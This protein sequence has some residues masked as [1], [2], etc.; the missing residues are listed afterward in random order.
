M[1]NKMIDETYRKHEVFAQLTKYAEFYKNLSSSIFSFVTLGTRSWGNIDTYT[2]SS[3]QGTIESISDILIKGRI[4]DSYALLRKYYDAAIINIYSN[5]YLADNFNCTNFIVQKIDNWMKGTEPLPEYRIMSEY[6]KK[7]PKLSEINKF[8]DNDERY[9]KIRNRCNDHTHYNFYK[10]ILLNDNEIFLKNRLKYLNIFSEDLENIFILH[11]SYLFYLNDHYMT[12]SDYMDSVNSGLP[13]T[14]GS[15]YFVAP[16]VQGIFDTVI[17]KN[18][19]DI[20]EKII[21]KTSMNL[22]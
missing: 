21:S 6:I 7:S 18:R 19:M 5:L 11:L 12:S 16:F 17:K 1:H 9:K 20:A 3:M 13:P 15:E 22:E 2:Y 14:E 4:N 10:N 8:L